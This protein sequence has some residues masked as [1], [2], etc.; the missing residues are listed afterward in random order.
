MEIDGDPCSAI[1]DRKTDGLSLW[2]IMQ[3]YW[4]EIYWVRCGTPVGLT[5]I[6]C[7]FLGFSSIALTFVGLD[8]WKTSLK[9]AT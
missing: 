4:C 3:F 8:R 2:E 1:N 9:F 6:Y 5:L 7:W